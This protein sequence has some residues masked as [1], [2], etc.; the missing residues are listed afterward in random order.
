MLVLRKCSNTETLFT[1]GK[2]VPT[3]L[4]QEEPKN[5][6]L[7]FVVAGRPTFS[8]PPSACL[9]GA[10]LELPENLQHP[11]DECAVS[12]VLILMSGIV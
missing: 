11:V 12:F 3:E 4:A 9:P 6:P 8:A 1:H 2:D 7:R 5:S 10:A